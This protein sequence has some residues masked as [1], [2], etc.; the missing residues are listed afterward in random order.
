M[1]DHSKNILNIKTPDY[2]NK[3]DSTG[4]DFFDRSLGGG[5]TP[6]MTYL[7]SGDPGAGKTTFSMQ[8]ADSLTSKD[9]LVIYNSTELSANRLSQMASDMSL[10]NGFLYYNIRNVLELKKEL[11]KANIQNPNKQLVFI[12]D[13]ISDLGDNSLKKVKESFSDLVDFAEENRFIFIAISHVNKSGS[14]SGSNALI[15]KTDVYFHIKNISK[16]KKIDDGNR[17]FIFK[18][19]RA[20]KCVDVFAKIK[21]RVFKDNDE[22]LDI[23]TLDE[24]IDEFDFDISEYEDIVLLAN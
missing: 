7:I 8:L 22:F 14:I 19:N 15:H 23:E 4:I 1:I 21:N 24:G 16:S 11:A 2:L 5:L 12:V 10:E 20:H 3:K 6:S 18:K 17:E 13:S 9:N